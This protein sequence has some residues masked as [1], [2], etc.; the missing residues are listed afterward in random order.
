MPTTAAEPSDHRSPAL[1]WLFAGIALGFF[2]ATARGYGYF[3]DELYYLVNGEHLGF[4]FVEHPP[5]VGLVAALVRSTLGDSLHAI[6]LLPAIAGAA[7][8]WLV[9]AMARELGGGRFAQGLAM[10]AA[11]FAPVYL[12]LFSEL[13]MNPFDVLFWAIAWW[14]LIRLLK[15]GDQRLWLAFG[16]VAGV[17]L[18]NKVSI[19]F[20]GFG[21]VVGLVA[22]RR[23]D[24]FRSRWLWI[25]GAVAVLLFSPY[26]IW[27]A[28]HGWPTL[29]FMENARR[30]KNVALSPAAF[31]GE[32]LLQAGPL[33]LPVWL[34]GLA[35]LLADRR[36]RPYR[37]LGW[38]YPA[39][40]GLML[41]AGGAK[42][43]YLAPT[44]TVLFAAGGVAIAT[45]T[46]GWRRTGPVVRWALLVLVA[47]SG[48]AIAPLAKPLLPVDAYVRYAAALG[49]TPTPEENTE[50]GRL[51]QHFADMHGWPELAATVAE[52]YHALPAADRA[53][54]CVFG[55]NYGEA[56][57][58]D[59][60]GRPL[61]LPPAISGHNSYFLWGPRGCTGEVVI[62]IGSDRERQ[63]EVFASVELAART[64]CDDCMPYENDRPVWVCRGLEAP[65]DQIWAEVGFY[66]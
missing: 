31:L 66:I 15:T 62:V 52:V 45:W 58:I 7:M 64:A 23:W 38:T 28:A 5:F 61:G 34:A 39:I 29:E 50:L 63:E 48:A 25:G 8:V 19:L 55:Q 9:G 4:G 6:R 65:I 21:L 12:S 27:N 32:Q 17:G 51:P 16:L 30:L 42:P 36:G 46:A 44:Y 60:L 40:L 47:V 49:E 56:A 53:R 3:R 24:V 1:S 14:L 59:V 37:A 26:V 13:S 35:F 33:A 41:A 57:A 11:F 54:A 18:Q 10:T 43:Y 20:L 2:V 22:A